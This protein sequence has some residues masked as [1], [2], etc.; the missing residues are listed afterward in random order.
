MSVQLEMAAIE[1]AI[2]RRHQLYALYTPTNLLDMKTTILIIFGQTLYISSIKSD[3][4]IQYFV[5]KH[6]HILVNTIVP[7]TGW[8]L[9]RLTL[10]ALRSLIV[11]GVLNFRTCGFSSTEKG[12]AAEDATEDNFP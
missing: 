11:S 3:G 4:V 9:Y 6:L 5:L 1:L 7:S 12:A 2:Q 8:I 10:N